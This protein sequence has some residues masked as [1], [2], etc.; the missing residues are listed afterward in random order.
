MVMIEELD[1]KGKKV[2][3]AVVYEEDSYSSDEDEDMVDLDLMESMLYNE[4]ND[5]DEDE[6]DYDD[7]DGENEDL[8][9]LEEEESDEDDSDE[10]DS[11]EDEEEAEQISEEMRYKSKGA[12]QGLY[13]QD[14]E[15][16][17]TLDLRNLIAVNAHQID[18]GELHRPSSESNNSM[19]DKKITIDANHAPVNED[20][21]LQKASEGCAQ[22]LTGLWN[23]DTQKSDAG[24]MAI[25]P[26]FFELPTPRSLVRY[27]LG[28]CVI[29]IPL[30]YSHECLGNLV[31]RSLR[32]HLKWKLNG[33]SLPRSVV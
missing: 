3:K 23:L 8:A 22:L 11:D 31:H 15:E 14:G 1:K 4:E 20:Y 27:H 32:H 6:S 28:L 13:T 30:S 26:S 33:K 12:S 16:M 17:W 7:E 21:L 24:P 29:I 25:L 10:D 9:I 2:R 18:H 5:M 19:V